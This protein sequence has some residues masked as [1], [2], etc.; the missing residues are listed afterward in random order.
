MQTFFLVPKKNVPQCK[1]KIIIT[2][3]KYRVQIPLKED[4]DLIF[5][6][7]IG[8][9][10]M[11]TVD[12]LRVRQK[13]GHDFHNRSCLHV[14]TRIKKLRPEPSAKNKALPPSV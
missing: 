12:I 10:R 3:L 14:P 9:W 5:Q 2:S 7:K 4:L 6:T 1:K 11:P 8:A 13:D